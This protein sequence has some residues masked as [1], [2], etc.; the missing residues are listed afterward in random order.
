M[1][2]FPIDIIIININSKVINSVFTLNIG[3]YSFH[4]VVNGVSFFDDFLS[5]FLRFP[6]V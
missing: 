5:F 2:L 3:F 1:K 6:Q 4:S